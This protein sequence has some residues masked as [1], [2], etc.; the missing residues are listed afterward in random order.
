MLFVIATL[1]YKDIVLHTVYLSNTL[2][3]SHRTGTD[4]YKSNPTRAEYT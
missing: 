3:V 1:R 4:V 2:T